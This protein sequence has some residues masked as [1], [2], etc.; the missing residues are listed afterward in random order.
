V[1]RVKIEMRKNKKGGETFGK[2]KRIKGRRKKG[3]KR[4][5]HKL[6]GENGKKEKGGR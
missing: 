5:I 4:G 1:G 3:R 2:K 6:K